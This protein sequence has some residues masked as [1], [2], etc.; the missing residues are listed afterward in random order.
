MIKRKSKVRSVK[1]SCMS[2]KERK[3][4]G[5]EIKSS[6]PECQ[7]PHHSCVWTVTREKRAYELAPAKIALS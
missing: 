2:E 3:K 7:L 5:R 6:P 1:I 4:G